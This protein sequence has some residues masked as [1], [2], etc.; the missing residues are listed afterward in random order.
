MGMDRGYCGAPA[1]ATARE[2]DAT[3]AT[4]AALLI[5]LIRAQIEPEPGP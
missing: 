3:L 5:D 4:L 1:E 2:G